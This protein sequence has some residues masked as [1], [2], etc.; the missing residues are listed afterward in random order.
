MYVELPAGLVHPSTIQRE[1]PAITPQGLAYP[2]SK[3][4]RA[5]KG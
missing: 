1:A 5:N 4:S 3:R 2:R